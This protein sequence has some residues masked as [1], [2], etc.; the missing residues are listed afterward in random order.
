MDGHPPHTFHRPNK[1]N[2]PY[3]ALEHPIIMNPN[4]QIPVPFANSRQPLI[5]RLHF[6]RSRAISV[7]VLINKL[8]TFR[9]NDVV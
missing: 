1:A 5:C 4:L 8:W 7:N 3:Y 2:K 6:T 9:A